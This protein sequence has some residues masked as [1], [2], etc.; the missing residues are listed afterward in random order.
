VDILNATNTAP[1]ESAEMAASHDQIVAV[2][3]LM[4]VQ[5]FALASLAQ[6]H[7]DPSAEVG[8]FQ[9]LICSVLA[10][11]DRALISEAVLRP[12]L[13]EIEAFLDA[14]PGPQVPAKWVSEAHLQRLSSMQTS[15]A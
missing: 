5:T 7:A 1:K 6:T 11:Q 2:H 8:L 10:L 3:P 9:T 13:L 15:N 12:Q 14:F 4:T